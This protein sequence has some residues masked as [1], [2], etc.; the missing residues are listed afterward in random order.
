[1]IDVTIDMNEIILKVG[2]EIH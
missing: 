1:M 2:F